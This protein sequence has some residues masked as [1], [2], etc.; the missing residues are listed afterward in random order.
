MDL[1]GFGEHFHSGESQTVPG[2]APGAMGPQRLDVSLL[3]V[4]IEPVFTVM[5]DVARLRRT[6]L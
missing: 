2:T 4:Q 1:L 5:T 3:G 6:D